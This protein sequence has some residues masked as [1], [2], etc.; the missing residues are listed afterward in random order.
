M[1][2]VYVIFSETANQY[3]I[4]LAKDV[5]IALWQHNAKANP[6]TAEGKPWV[7]KFKQGFPKRTEAQS[8]EMKLKNKKREGLE[9]F[10]SE[11][12]AH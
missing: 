5:Q 6:T 4:G 8:L 11:Q 1:V 9:E 2:Y 10:L 12:A 3:F 7:V